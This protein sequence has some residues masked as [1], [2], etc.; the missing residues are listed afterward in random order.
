[1]DRVLGGL[2]VH[3]DQ[4]VHLMVGAAH[5]DAER[6]PDPERFDPLR[7]PAHLAF[8]SGIHYCLGAPLARLEAETLLRRLVTRLPRL[9]LVRR[10]TMAPRRVVFR[11]LMNLD[12][13]LA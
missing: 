12:V 3:R 10:P 9:T 4:M 5:H 6:H 8:S 13:A 2:E 7:K 1:D 11:R